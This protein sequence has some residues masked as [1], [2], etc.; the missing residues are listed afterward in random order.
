MN[1]V[2]V[3]SLHNRL[4]GTSHGALE[5]LIDARDGAG[6]AYFRPRCRID[7]STYEEKITERSQSDL[8]TG[9]EQTRSR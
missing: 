3:H 2:S 6:L 7:V 9:A 4:K 5:S 8:S 1:D